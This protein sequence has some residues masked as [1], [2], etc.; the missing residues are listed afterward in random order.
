MHAGQPAVALADRGADGV[1]DD[2][3]THAGLHDSCDDLCLWVVHHAASPAS[4]RPRCATLGDRV[5]T[6]GSSGAE[7]AHGYRDHEPRDWRGRTHVFARTPTSRSRTP[8]RG[9]T[10]PTA[11]AA[12]TFAERATADA[13]R[14]PTSWKPSNE[15][16]RA[17]HDPRDGQDARGR[18]GPRRQVRQGHALLRRARRGASSPTSRWPTRRRS[19]RRR[20]TRATSRSGRCSRSCPGTSRCGR[21]SASPPP[22][23]W[24]ATSGCSSTPRTCP[25]SALYLEDL[26]VRAG[27]PEGAF[28]TL[29]IG[30]APRSRRSC[31]TRGSRP[32]R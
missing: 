10:R 1:D 18:R 12:T 23:S 19:R 30:G 16:H 22:R 29:L 6:E 20:R 14:P 31:A 4:T 17:D 26:F 27:F 2:R 5:A 24:R 15:S 25:Q 11:L 7:S 13:A 32:R 9:P 3:V 8:S 21:S 28:Q